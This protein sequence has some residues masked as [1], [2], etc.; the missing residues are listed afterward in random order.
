MR[1]AVFSLNRVQIDKE[2]TPGTAVAAKE[3]L[4]ATAEVTLDYPLFRNEAPTGIMVVNSGPTKL[5]SKDVDISLNFDG[6]TY[7]QMG[8]VLGMIDKAS[9]SGVGP[10]THDYAPG[11]AGSY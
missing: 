11:M 2:A 4:L 3:L 6:I 9:T 5:L 10:Y 7:E 8:W 1:G